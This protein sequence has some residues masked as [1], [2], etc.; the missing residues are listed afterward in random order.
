MTELQTK[1]L[2]AFEMVAKAYP[3]AFQVLMLLQRE[4]RSA[5]IV[6]GAKY[7]ADKTGL[8]ESRI[9]DD[10]NILQGRELITVTQSRGVLTIELNIVVVPS[11]N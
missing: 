11:S 8:G 9:L 7:L 10:L 2:H 5:S 3:S 4:E 1:R 6:C